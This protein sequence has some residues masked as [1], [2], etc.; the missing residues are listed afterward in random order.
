MT[1]LPSF[2]QLLLPPK[3]EKCREIPNEFFSLRQ[4]NVIQG[5][6]SWCQ[7]KAHK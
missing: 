1:G 7:W 2:V 4:F 3:H 5:H 6:R